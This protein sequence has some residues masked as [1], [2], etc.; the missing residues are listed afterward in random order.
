MSNLLLGQ[1]RSEIYAQFRLMLPAFGL[2][3]FLNNTPIVAIFIP[4][5]QDW[6]KRHHL[7]FLN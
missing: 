3:A 5:I 4:A 6:A 1:P 7:K 2:S